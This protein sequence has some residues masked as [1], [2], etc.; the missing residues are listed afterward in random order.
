LRER[1]AEFP[2][3]YH[4]I[5]L[6]GGVITPGF[7]PINQEAYRIPADLSGLRVLDVMVIEFYPDN[8][9]GNNNTNWWVPSL[10]CLAHMVRAAGF[11]PVDA[12]KLMDQ[13]TQVSLCRGF[14]RGNKPVK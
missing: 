6:P 5:H 13:P 3:W 14:V 11:D 12:W 1:V 4:K 2:F 8:Q 7:A 9:Y 10:V